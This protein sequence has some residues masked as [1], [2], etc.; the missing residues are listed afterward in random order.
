MSKAIRLAKHLP[1]APT[2]KQVSG[3]VLL[4]WQDSANRWHIQDRRERLKPRLTYLAVWKDGHSVIWTTQCTCTD[5]ERC[6]SSLAFERAGKLGC[7]STSLE[8]LGVE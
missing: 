1:C 6:P 7:P 3:C 2:K 5:P 8:T 4:L